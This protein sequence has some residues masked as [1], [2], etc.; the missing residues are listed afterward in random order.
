MAVALQQGDH[1]N[2]RGRHLPAGKALEHGHPLHQARGPLQLCLLGLDQLAALLAVAEVVFQFL[3]GF[4]EV[5]QQASGF[6]PCLLEIVLVALEA[7][8]KH[9]ELVFQALLL[10]GHG[11]PLTPAAGFD[12]GLA[13]AGLGQLPLGVLQ[14][15]QLLLQ[16]LQGEAQLLVAV[17]E[18]TALMHEL[19]AEL[20]ALALAVAQALLQVVEAGLELAQFLVAAG[21]SLA[22]VLQLGAELVAL[23]VVVVE[24]VL[25][26]VE[27]GLE[28][29]QF[30]VAAGESLAFV[31]ELGAE[32][33]AAALQEAQLLIVGHKQA[34]ALP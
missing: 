9:V 21:E 11:V 28:V 29:A 16:S 12:L 24:V 15:L 23:A 25:E 22:L 6:L 17:D 5:L 14:A 19:G 27:A 20:I 33:V 10:L 1:L 13:G 31:L 3:F 18:G 2:R 4:V 34:F 7:H 32:L 26:V 30:L 8:L